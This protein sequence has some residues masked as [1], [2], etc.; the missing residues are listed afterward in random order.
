MVCGHLWMQLRLL[1]PLI[2]WDHKSCRCMHLMYFLNICPIT[3][4]RMVSLSLP[5]PERHYNSPNCKQFMRSWFEASAAMLV[6]FALFS[7]ITQRRAV[8]LYR[9]FGSTY[10]SHLQGSKSPRPLNMGPT[11]CPETSVKY[12]HSTLH[13]I[14]EERKSQLYASFRRCF[15]WQTKAGRFGLYFCQT[16]SRAIF[17][18]VLC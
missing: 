3:T 17:V 2:F 7:D 18:G 13:N 9:R 12:Y 8:I 15:W 1:G 14:R 6:R 10:P 4:E 16:W 5:P 11:G